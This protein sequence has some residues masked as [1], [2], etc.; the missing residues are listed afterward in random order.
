MLLCSLYPLNPCDLRQR[1]IA[2]PQKNVKTR[3]EK[4]KDSHKSRL[5]AR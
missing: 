5:E 4:Y 3:E 1:I 2:Q